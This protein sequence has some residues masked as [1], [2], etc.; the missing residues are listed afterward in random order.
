MKN[1]FKNFSFR[2]Y[3]KTLLI[4][5]ASVFLLF[6]VGGV[7]AY[8]KRE[9]LLKTVIEKSIAK[10]K[11][12]YNLNVKIGSYR[13]SGLSTVHFENIT[14]VPNQRDSLANI[15][16][17]TIGVKLFPLIFGKVKISELGIE[18]SLI[19]L[20][21]KDSISNYDFIFK[22]DKKDSTKKS[23]IDLSDLANK[24][25][26]Q[27]LDKI[28]EEMNIKQFMIRF[29]EDTTHV[30]LLT[31]TATINNGEVNSTLK[32]NGNEAIWHVA[33]TADP[34]NQQLD[35]KFYGDRK[36]VE[37]PYLENKYALKLNFDTVRTIMTSAKKVGDEFEIEGSWSVK[38]LLINHMRIA[39]NDVIIKDG[40]I[41]AKILVGSNY[42]G[43]DSTSVIYL[44]K[45]QI[46]PFIKYTIKPHKIY[47][48]QL[49]AFDQEAQDIFDAF[50]V[51]LFESLEGIKVNGRLRY[52]LNFYLDSSNPDKVIFNSALTGSDDFKITQF[53][54]TNFQKINSAFIYTPF[55][56]GKPVRPILI[57]PE[58]PNYTPIDQ[59][60]P[61]IRN[62]LL[63]SEDPSFYTHNG[64]V[65][66]SIRQ[67]IATNFKAKSFKRGGSTISMQLVKNVYLNR[68]KNLARK[69][70]E[71]L[72]VWLIENQKLTP[73]S[74]LY[75]VYLNIIEWGRNVYGIGEAARYYFSKTPAE[76][77]IGEAIYLAHIVPKPKSS[78]YAWQS[79]GSLKPYLSGYYRLIGGLMARRGYTTNDSSNYGYYGVRLKESLRQQIAPSDFIPDSLSEEEDNNFFNLNIFNP[80]KKDSLSKKEPF[81]NKSIVSPENKKDTTN[82]TPK[83]LRL[84]KR[85]KRKEN[86][87]N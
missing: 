16:N 70:E 30:S 24:L 13:F 75:E 40:S 11:S 5:F 74:R 65:E 87:I 46:N 51:G 84:E 29:D 36:K 19:S 41:D 80:S 61:N 8:S 14:V 44:G 22:K 79:D 3:K 1:I 73:K 69:I 38:N 76:L 23:A 7:I 35:L 17:L 42:V 20:T 4:V 54:K 53:G 71:I 78:L 2:K 86:I 37:F 43:L 15:K 39:A 57:G 18:N 72:I 58:N 55:E 34:S 25:I 45:A 64:F 52:D 26:N 62:A 68:Q 6:F 50:P 59:I 9:A 31:E 28:P 56:K 10:A 67:S 81:S 66:E 21:K 27:T 77:T 12:K 33:G 85:Q 60:S 32:V 48:M 47:E 83:E 63:T 49:H 82:K